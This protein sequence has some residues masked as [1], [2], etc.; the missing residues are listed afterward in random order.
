MS[1]NKILSHLRDIRIGNNIDQVDLAEISGYDRTNI[2][3]YE[4]GKKIPN[5][6]TAVDLANSLDH[7]IVVVP[8]NQKAKKRRAFRARYLEQQH[9]EHLEKLIL[10]Y[11]ELGY[12][13][14]EAGK[15]LGQVV[16]ESRHVIK[17]PKD[18]SNMNK[19]LNIIIEKLKGY[20]HYAG[21]GWTA[22]TRSPYEDTCARSDV[23]A[24]LN[25]TF[26]GCRIIEQEE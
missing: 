8:I 7:K 4:T 5:L 9:P 12:R 25:R 21:E 18:S 23:V 26:P 15:T 16:R 3:K 11:L 10:H 19:T 2:V 13:G 24:Y 17:K 6:A 14:K 1:V 20:W 22:K